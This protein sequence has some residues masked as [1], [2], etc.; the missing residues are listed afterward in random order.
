MNNK[1]LDSEE[2][3]NVIIYKYVASKEENIDIIKVQM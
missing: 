3:N 1:F 2:K